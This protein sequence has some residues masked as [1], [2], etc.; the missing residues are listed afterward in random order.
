[1]HG[2]SRHEDIFTFMECGI[3]MH[4]CGNLVFCRGAASDLICVR[5]DAVS[6]GEKFCD[7]SKDPVAFSLD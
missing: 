7:A 5:R 4:D 3:D 1:V 2:F 6:L